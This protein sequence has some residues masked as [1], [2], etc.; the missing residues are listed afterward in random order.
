[1]VWISVWNVDIPKRITE[2]VNVSVDLICITGITPDNAFMVLDFVSASKERFFSWI[3]FSVTLV[4]N[5][6]VSISTFVEVSVY[7]FSISSAIASKWSWV[8]SVVEF[9]SL[10]IFCKAKANTV[11]WF[12]FSYKKSLIPPSPL[13]ATGS[14]IVIS[15]ELSIP[16]AALILDGDSINDAIVV[17]GVTTL[18]SVYPLKAWEIKK[19]SNWIWES[20]S[21]PPMDNKLPFEY[22]IKNLPSLSDVVDASLSPQIQSSFSSTHISDPDI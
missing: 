1:M 12:P 15:I 14:K 19:L 22:L 4:T 3:M 6:S 17:M 9:K 5:A 11:N 7:S 8:V 13:F 21:V 10:V 18:K 16:R 20:K 2:V